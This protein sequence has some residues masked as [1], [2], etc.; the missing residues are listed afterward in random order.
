[1][2]EHLAFVL[3][4]IMVLSRGLNDELFILHFLIGDLPTITQTRQS[5]LPFDFS[6]RVFGGV[7]TSMSDSPNPL[8][9]LP[10]AKGDI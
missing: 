5:C 2:N 10:S 9:D 1:M 3:A 6:F 8:G 7:N 4:S